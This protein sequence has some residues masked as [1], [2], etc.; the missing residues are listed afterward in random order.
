M[1]KS[2]I[3]S[4]IINTFDNVKIKYIHRIAVD[5]C[6][7]WVLLLAIRLDKDVVCNCGCDNSSVHIKKVIMEI[8]PSVIEIHNTYETAPN[9][10]DTF[11]YSFFRDVIQCL[12]AQDDCRVI[13]NDV[14]VYRV[15][16]VTYVMYDLFFNVKG[17]NKDL[18]Y[19]VD[20]HLTE[21]MGVKVKSKMLDPGP[22][23]TLRETFR[24]IDSDE[25][26]DNITEEDFLIN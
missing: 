6:D 15:L 7:S 22:L 13:V 23:I 10:T 3:I 17:S 19:I 12:Y 5:E 25:N 18:N 16:N 1:S 2:D 4:F 21:L 14:Y 26:S 8:F 11:N 9:Y 24:S 20:E